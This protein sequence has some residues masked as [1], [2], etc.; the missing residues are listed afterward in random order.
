MAGSRGIQQ[1]HHQQQQ[2]PA[3]TRS[4]TNGEP[5]SSLERRDRDRHRNNFITFTS[6]R[7]H[8]SPDGSVV[9]TITTNNNGRDHDEPGGR[10]RT[11]VV[12]V[13][14]PPPPPHSRDGGGDGNM[15][16][17]TMD[18]AAADERILRMLLHHAHRTAASLM[19]YHHDG[20]GGNVERMSYEELLE[21][22][23]VGNEHR[24]GASP[25]T[26][27]SIPSM[28]ISDQETIDGLPDH[29]KTCN[30]C[31]EDFAVGDHVR[32]LVR[33]THAFHATC[34]DRW[35]ER[36][37][38]CPICKTSVS[39]DH[40][41]DHNNNNHNHNNNPTSSASPRRGSTTEHES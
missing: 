2:Q 3:S 11:V 20:T 10:M 1:H 24:R 22:F 13:P 28:K 14:P 6:S 39:N 4:T 18:S 25:E 29:Q 9:H 23:G 15:T 16:M 31:L 27:S 21:R 7:V 40:G 26:I 12:R 37:A 19:P 41:D 17:M 38:S 30:I 34:L 32:K 35:L 36:V 5:R 8:R 33:C